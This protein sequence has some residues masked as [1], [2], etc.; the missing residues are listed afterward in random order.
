MSN[1]NRIAVVDAG[2]GNLGSVANSFVRVGAQPYL[3]ET[4][5]KLEGAHAIVLPGVGA[6]AEAMANLSSRG[7]VEPLRAHAAK[8]GHLMGICLGMQ[9][10]ADVSE[11]HGEWQGLGIIPGRVRRLSPLDPAARVPHIGWA[12]AVPSK[13]NVL[14]PTPGSF[15]HV[16]SYWFDCADPADIA[17][18]IDHGG[19]R[20]TVAIERG[21]IMG[22]QFHPEKSQDDGLDL[23]ARFV[24]SV[25]TTTE[26]L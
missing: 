7:F 3:V 9:L 8:G 4:P 12:E 6:F 5:E 10:L 13:G 14:L 15:Y 17:A 26:T 25:A 11:E 19:R 16:H 2:L 24:Q 18:T 21:P 1:F 22:V 23:L 20:V